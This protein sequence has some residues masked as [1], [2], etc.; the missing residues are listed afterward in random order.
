MPR[1]LNEECERFF[2]DCPPNTFLVPETSFVP[3][4]GAALFLR[5]IKQMMNFL[6]GHGLKCVRADFPFYVRSLLSH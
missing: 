3:L 5:T 1:P 6:E 2:L 4:I